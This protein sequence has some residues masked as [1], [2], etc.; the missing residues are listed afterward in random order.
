MSP[1]CKR[2]KLHLAAGLF[3]L[4]TVWSEITAPL[5]PPKTRSQPCVHFLLFLQCRIWEEARKSWSESQFIL[6]ICTFPICYMMMLTCQNTKKKCQTKEVL[7]SM[8][9]LWLQNFVVEDYLPYWE[10][11]FSAGEQKYIKVGSSVV[12]KWPLY[13]PHSF[14]SIRSKYFFNLVFV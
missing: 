3:F 4:W 14:C 12:C 7:A 10:F 1:P 9:C 6:S 13:S 11:F 2:F 8:T 5:Y